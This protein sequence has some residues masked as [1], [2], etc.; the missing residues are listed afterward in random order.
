MTHAQGGPVL[1]WI[2]NLAAAGEAGAQGDARLLERFA[3]QRDEA[4]FA[5]LVERHGP[6]ILGVCRRLLRQEQDA[7]DAFQAT[8]LVLARRAGSI[9]KG[10]SVAS[11]LYGVA[12]RVAGKARSAAARRRE[13]Q[14]ELRDVPAAEATPAWVGRELRAV[15]DEEVGRLP[16]RYRLPFV[17]CHLEGKTNE[18]AAR[19]LGRPLGTVLA[20]LSRA[21]A[22]LRHRLLRRGVALSV[23]AL[24]AAVAHEA[25][26]AAVPAGLAAAT[27]KGAVTF[28]P[29]TAAAPGAVST[30]AAALA[31]GVLHTMFRTKLMTAAA[32]VLAV[33]LAGVG[34]GLLAQQ[35]AAP[36]P[37]DGKPAAKGAD[38]SADKLQGTWQAESATFGGKAVDLAEN[39]IP[40]EM[41]FDAGKV[42]A[43]NKKGDAAEGTYTADPTKDPKELDIAMTSGPSNGKTLRA[44]YALEGGRLKLCGG[45]PDGERPTEVA[46]REGQEVLLVVF[47]KKP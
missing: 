2:R 42:T 39:D 14:A 24:A 31:E 37:A 33:C 45:Q 10:E 29:G 7:E 32:A 16:A 3:G 27:V 1:R 13:R 35:A 38:G 30:Q 36:K 19:E 5:R 12:L 22:R 47:K 15:L 43:R 44:V 26:P 6:L 11:W 20:Q 25:A 21:R 9:R 28:V 4:A 23:A 46:S 40:Y 34:A 17:L 8:F 18:E 41:T